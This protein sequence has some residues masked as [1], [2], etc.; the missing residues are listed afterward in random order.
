MLI[1]HNL[2]KV[3]AYADHQRAEKRGIGADSMS[4]RHPFPIHLSRSTRFSKRLEKSCG[5]TGLAYNRDGIPILVPGG[6][7]ATKGGMHSMSVPLQ[8]S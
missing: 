1:L 6:H 8:D 7:G 3:Q 5:Y 4:P 2:P